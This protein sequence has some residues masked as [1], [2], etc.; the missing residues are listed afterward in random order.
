MQDFFQ[1]IRQFISRLSQGQQI[2]LGL[3]VLGGLAIILSIAVWSS[4]TDYAL[5]FG[6]LDADDANA[7][8][9]SLRE[10]GISY[11]LRQNGTSV[12]V[13]REDVYE[14]RMRYASEGVISNGPIGYELF[15][16]GNMGMT[17]F[18]QQVNK[19][20][21]LEGELA[22]TISNM[23]QVEMAR[24]HLVL[25]ERNPFREDEVEAS[26]SV[27]I[28]HASSAKLKSA[29]VDGIMALVGGA[30]EGMDA[31]SVT[32]LDAQGNMLSDPNAGDPDARLTSTQL[33]IQRE[34]ENHLLENGQSMLDRVLGTGHSIVR[35]SADLDFSRTVSESDVID[36]E[37]QTVISE[38]RLDEDSPQDNA[39]SLV[40]NYEVSRTLERFEDSPG[41]IE[42]LTV[43]VILNQKMPP[44]GEGEEP[45]P[46]TQ[47][48]LDEIEAI[49]KNA[50]GFDEERGDQF[51]IHQTRF[52]PDAN[53]P[54]VDQLREEQRQ[55]QIEQYV[56]Y[57]L[58][59]MALLLGVWLIRSIA[60]RGGELDEDGLLL[61]GAG[62]Q[63][64]DEEDAL[65]A[66]RRQQQG[67]DGDIED[68]MLV[69]DVYTSK[70]SPEAQQALRRKHRLYQEVQTQVL[71]HP[72]EAAELI[73]TWLIEDALAQEREHRKKQQAPTA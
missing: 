10:E 29:Q 1:N 48:E 58:I 35:L 69:D 8:V 52:S 7:V 36:P 61:P 31:S 34:I 21:A 23:Q 2:A 67:E 40:R 4:Q 16:Q 30:V 43:S 46:Y 17:D 37:S 27:V 5:L 45:I 19:K 73:R 65:M 63:Q 56:R 18:M 39:S 51:A 64:G 57:G 44:E 71:E 70:L 20:R 25:P 14:L 54:M 49:V 9:E 33:E 13:P 22:R 62:A 66:A 24:V 72:E 53:N 41:G 15:D 6:D 38:E 50:V 3:V 68:L 60:K 12:Y 32:V 59:L 42:G 26:A 47:E 55:Q 28:Q 11:E